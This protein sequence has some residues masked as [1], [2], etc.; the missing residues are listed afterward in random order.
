MVVV[1]V[2]IVV[3][4]VCCQHGIVICSGEAPGREALRRVVVVAVVLMAIVVL[5]VCCQHGMSICSGEAS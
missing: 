3:L 4:S 2:A 5:S 1:L